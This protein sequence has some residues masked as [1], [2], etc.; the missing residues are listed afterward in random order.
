MKKP[1]IFDV[2][3]SKINLKLSCYDLFWGT[4]IKC[5]YV[6][7]TND[8]PSVDKLHSDGVFCKF[9]EKHCMEIAGGILDCP[10]LYVCQRAK[11]DPIDSCAFRNRGRLKDECADD[12]CQINDGTLKQHSAL[13]KISK[14]DLEIFSYLF[15]SVFRHMDKS[16]FILANI[17]KLILFH[18]YNFP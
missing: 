3:G 13:R 9:H 14:V 1:Q 6:P 10:I 12:Q 5:K 2:K 4:G 8:K 17:L 7:P 16:H 15:Y 18:F 11:H